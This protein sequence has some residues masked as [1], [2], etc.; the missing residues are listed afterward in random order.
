M[1]IGISL[2]D[3]RSGST[4]KSKP[5]SGSIPTHRKALESSDLTAAFDAAS[6]RAQLTD[7]NGTPYQLTNDQADE[8]FLL[9][10]PTRVYR[11][12]EPPAGAEEEAEEGE[13]EEE[14]DSWASSKSSS[15]LPEF[16]MVAL[17]LDS[18][19]RSLRIMHNAQR[20][21]KDLID[22]LCRS[23][24][25]THARDLKNDWMVLVEP[26]FWNIRVSTIDLS[27]DQHLEDQHLEDQQL[28]GDQYL[29]DDQCSSRASP[30]FED[31][32]LVREFIYTLE[33]DF[34]DTTAPTLSV[35]GYELQVD[36]SFVVSF[37]EFEPE[38]G[39]SNRPNVVHLR[40]IREKAEAL[41]RTIPSNNSRESQSIQAVIGRLVGLPPQLSVKE[42]GR[43]KEKI[44]KWRES[45][46]SNQTRKGRPIVVGELLQPQL[47]AVAS[48]LT[49]QELT[50]DLQAEIDLEPGAVQLDAVI[51]N[52]P[53]SG[54]GFGTPAGSCCHSP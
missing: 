18:D 14:G 46:Q 15:Q 26:K 3:P 8:I 33:D 38:Q 30:T 4:L 13:A 53:A 23:L 37:Q 27:G 42:S 40:D 22:D 43:A 47:L 21:F 32:G 24:S 52:Y 7:P 41:T 25:R 34:A 29:D 11:G 35:S 5:T 19:I 44:D 51:P 16:W 1:G 20:L 39:T 54:F 9:E 10:A 12:R 50:F 31:Y 6:L 45:L 48:K 2:T 17:T 36:G 49:K 28:S